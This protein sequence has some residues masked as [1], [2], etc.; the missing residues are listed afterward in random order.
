MAGIRKRKGE[1]LVKLAN[2]DELIPLALYIRVSSIG[3]DVE[4][5]VDAQLKHLKEWAKENGYVI[6][7]IFIDEAKSGR[8]GNRPNFQEMIREAEEPDCPF[9]A[10]AVYKFSRFYRNF[11]ESSYY[12]FLLK[13][14]GIPVIS[15]NESM[16]DTAAGRLSEGMLELVYQ[17]Q[18]ENTG[19]EVHRGTHNLAERGFFLG[20]RAPHGMM[21]VQVEDGRKMRNR[22]AP[23][24]E[25]APYIRR[26]F[27]L[28]LEEKTEKQVTKA[29]NKE[30]IPNPSGRPW[31]AQR[32]HD[33]LT[34]VHYAT[35]I[36]WA[37]RTD[38]PTITWGAHEGIVTKDEYQKVEELL[39]SRAPEV[40][41]P[42]NEG[43]EHPFSGMMKCMNCKSPYTYAPA[44]MNGKRYLYVVCQNR[45][46]NG[47]EAC[48]SPWIPAPEFEARALAAIT[49]DVATRENI[50]SAIEELRA[51]SG[52]EYDRATR[53]LE[54]NDK[55]R[56]DVEARRDR[57][58]AAYE[59]GSMELERY[60]ERNRELREMHEAIV[61]ERRQILES[62]GSR[63]IILD[64]PE[65]V[66]ER[67]DKISQHLRENEPV[68]CR[69]WLKRFIRRIWIE[70]GQGV[71]EYTIPL[72]S[73]AEFSSSTRREFALSGDFRPTARGAPLPCVN[74]N[75]CFRK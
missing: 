67:M 51:E 61:A 33:V 53:K 23:D 59:S 73:E 75:T 47:K 4:N 9:E 62:S 32:I 68:R 69:S 6:V 19:E 54:E 43:S 18:S 49:E 3:Q 46:E 22:L 37:M 63:T 40:S 70:Y 41:N 5:S 31:K 30:G 34:N 38:E 55:R 17:F 8:S 52:E 72:P 1:I 16:E 27:D 11:D 24:P 74:P 12:K 25:T 71:V 13:K 36:G 56:R 10:V 44:A 66:L 20:A 50:K 35:A 64:N 14:K 39:E 21:K 60:T 15:I 7:R 28:A 57:M 48:D 42:R 2:T 45:K 65:A 58:Y 29:A 26:I